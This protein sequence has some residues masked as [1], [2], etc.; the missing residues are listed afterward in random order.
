MFS[1]TSS[2]IRMSLEM[3]NLRFCRTISRDFALLFAI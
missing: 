3:E 1:D 2:D